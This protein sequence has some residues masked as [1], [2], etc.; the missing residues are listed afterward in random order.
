M[1]PL[2][3][4]R[5]AKRKNEEEVRE[6]YNFLVERRNLKKKRL[7]FSETFAKNLVQKTITERGGISRRRRGR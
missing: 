5:H 3:K 2:Y 7:E 6:G 1:M 4:S